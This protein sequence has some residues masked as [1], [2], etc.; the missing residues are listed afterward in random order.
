MPQTAPHVQNRPRPSK[1]KALNDQA[2]EVL[3]PP[4]IALTPKKGAEWPDALS[5]VIL[6]PQSQ[7]S[8]SKALSTL[9]G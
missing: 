6:E 2:E 9:R 3:V 5:V 4:E 1:A 8:V 7:W